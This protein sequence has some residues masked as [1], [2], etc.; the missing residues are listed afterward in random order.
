MAA[1]PHAQMLIHKHIHKCTC[2]HTSTH[3][4]ATFCI[5]HFA[6]L[7]ASSPPL[8]P[9]E[10]L[11]FLEPSSPLPHSPGEQRCLLTRAGMKKTLG[12]PAMTGY[13]LRNRQKEHRQSGI[14]IPTHLQIPI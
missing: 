7:Q 6:N 10:V 2:M 11:P 8:L 4:N 5:K 1:L 12:V 14:L 3:T 9:I 13:V